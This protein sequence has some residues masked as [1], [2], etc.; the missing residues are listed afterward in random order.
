MPSSS[1]LESGIAM[2]LFRSSRNP[3]AGSWYP[4]VIHRVLIVLSSFTEF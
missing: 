2:H 3:Q 4:R 1:F